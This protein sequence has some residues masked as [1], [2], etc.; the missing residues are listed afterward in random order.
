MTEKY[1]LTHDLG[2]SSNKAVL[3]N[4]YGRL[5]AEARHD[6]T[7]HYPQAN[8]AEQDPYDW[9]HAV[10]TSTH[11][12]M[13]M[14]GISPDQ[15]AGITF[16]CQMQT[17]VA[18]D[19]KGVPVMPA[20]SWLDTRGQEILYDKL[21]TWPRIIGYQPLRLL[22]FLRVTGGAPGHTGKD[23]I[24]KIIWLKEKKPELFAKTA[25]F[26]DV[27]DFVIY[28]L[29]GNWCKS[30]DLAAVWWLLDTRKNRNRWD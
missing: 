13:Q 3:F 4:L 15:I 12:A 24:A 26:L 23:P 6:Y 14:A 29:T 2:T 18:V 21:W 20:I 8:Y 16:S 25:K 19:E 10:Y 27:K 7:V 1:I 30:V 11:K 9:L 28:H 17:V 22:R 5:I